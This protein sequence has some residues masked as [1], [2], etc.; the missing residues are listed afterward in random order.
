MNGFA[1]GK[2]LLA[3]IA[4]ATS[5]VLIYRQAAAAAEV[6]VGA[7]CRK[8]DRPSLDRFDHS[9]FDALLR[10]YVDAQGLVDYSSWKASAPAVK[11]LDAYLAVAGCVDLSKAASKEARLAYWINLYNALTIKGILREYPTTSIR[12]H[13]KVVGYN[14]WKRLLIAVD[15][16]YFSLHQI[17]HEVLRKMDEPRIHFAIVCASIGCPKLRNEAYAPGRIAEQFE[18]NAR[19]FFAQERNFRFDRS[20]G[21]FH[22]SAIL[23]WFADDFGS[24]TAARMKAIAR[25]LPDSEARLLAEQGTARARYLDYDWNIND[26]NPARSAGRGAR[27]R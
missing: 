17:E 12:N 11:Q 8:P 20:N 13:T 6:R 22:L 18:D 25:Y 9:T 27:V 4:V 7:P 23:K 24:S 10:S 1:K 26:R 15:D 21:T 14:I 5:C 2:L 3:G 19:D 16:R